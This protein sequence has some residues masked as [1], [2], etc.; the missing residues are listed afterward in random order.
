MKR[1]IASLL[2]FSIVFVLIPFPAN[3]V[4]AKKNFVKNETV[5]RNIVEFLEIASNRLTLYTEDIGLDSRDYFNPLT[6]I[7]TNYDT[8]YNIQTSFGS[9]TVSNEDNTIASAIIMSFTTEGYKDI[10]GKLC[11]CIASIS[12]LEFD[13][14]DD[15]RFPTQYSIGLSESKNAIEE[16]CRIWDEEIYKNLTKSLNTS[17]SKDSAILLYSGNYDY[18]VTYYDY[19]ESILVV[20]TAEKR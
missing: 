20:I 5:C 16:T 6:G 8:H 12:A 14:F 13:A 1:I 18:Y 2:V 11:R 15:D 7:I 17:V 19:D 10:S 4:F 3:A 9:I